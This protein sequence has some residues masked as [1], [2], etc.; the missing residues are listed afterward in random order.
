M[1][2]DKASPYGHRRK[3]AIPPLIPSEGLR[4][5]PRTVPLSLE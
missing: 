2:W 4:I 1:G 3:M 5:G